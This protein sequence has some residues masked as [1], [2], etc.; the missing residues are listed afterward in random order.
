MGVALRGWILQPK[1]PTTAEP[2]V[3]STWNS[4]SSSRLTRVVQL[5]LSCAVMPPSRPKTAYAASSAVAG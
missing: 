3:P 2:C 4:T 5:E 1:R